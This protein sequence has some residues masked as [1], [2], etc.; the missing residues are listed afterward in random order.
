[1]NSL[2]MFL[3]FNRETSISVRILGILTRKAFVWRHLFA[4]PLRSP[5][6]IHLLTYRISCKQYHLSHLQNKVLEIRWNYIYQATMS[7]GLFCV[8]LEYIGI[9]CINR[10]YSRL[11][12]KKFISVS[13]EITSSMLFSESTI[14]FPS[15]ICCIHHIMLINNLLFESKYLQSFFIIC[16]LIYL[17]FK[18][19]QFR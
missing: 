13:S 3:R 11:Y 10:W 5:L 6:L 8:L 14:S 7:H 9:D 18:I 12:F 15:F 1:M 4:A 17:F 2:S 16:V 19:R